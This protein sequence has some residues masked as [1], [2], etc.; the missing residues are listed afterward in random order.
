VLRRGSAQRLADRNAGPPGADFPVPTLV[1]IGEKDDWSSPGVCR[2]IKDKPNL[3]V[4]VQPAATNS[5][6]FPE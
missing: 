4:V 6:A 3:E 1:L 5:F 2:A